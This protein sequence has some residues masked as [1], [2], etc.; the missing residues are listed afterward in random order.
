M[1]GNAADVLTDRLHDQCVFE[2]RIARQLRTAP[3]QDRLRLYTE[4]YSEYA[5]KFPDSLPKDSSAAERNAVYETAFLRR[6]LKPSTIM[7]EIG[8][9]RCHLAVSLAPHVARIYGVD[10]SPVGA[11]AD[12]AE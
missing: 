5:E 8:P 12:A 9:G 4:L 10:V 11:G 3:Q 2:T 7:A 6:F 1:N